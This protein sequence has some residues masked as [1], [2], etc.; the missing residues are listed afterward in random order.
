MH[1]SAAAILSSWENDEKNI[2]TKHVDAVKLENVAEVHF[3]GF[4][5]FSCFYRMLQLRLSLREIKVYL[6]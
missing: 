3:G 2:A 1:F 5:S 4:S 6:Q